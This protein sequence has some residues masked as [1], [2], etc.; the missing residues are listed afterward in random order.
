MCVAMGAAG[1]PL[2]VGIATDVIVMREGMTLMLIDEVTAAAVGVANVGVDEVH[3]CHVSE[4][5]I[6]DIMEDDM[7]MYMEEDMEDIMEDIIELAITEEGM[8]G[9]A[10][11]EETCAVV[12]PSLGRV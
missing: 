4:D 11:K 8:G 7:D 10:T 9:A 2:A 12:L 3:A 1:H 5:I 6:E